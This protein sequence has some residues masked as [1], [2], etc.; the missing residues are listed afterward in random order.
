MTYRLNFG[1]KVVMAGY[2]WYIE[3]AAEKILVDAGGNSEY[4]ARTR[5]VRVRTIQS[6]DA[7]L[8][9][10]GIN[11]VD[12]DLVILTHLHHDHVAQAALFSRA[13]F[14]VQRAELEF[15]QKPHP[16]FTWAYPGEFFEGLDFEVISGDRSICDG[17]S[18]LS[19]PG[20]TPGGGQSVCVKVTH[21]IAIIPGLCTIRE[22]Y[23]P[24]STID[25]PVIPPSIHT[26]VLTA[27][28]S[29]LR[30]KRTADIIVPPHDTEF[31]V[32]TC[33]V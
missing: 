22:N 11:P 27:Y 16:L 7:G 15:A 12:I 33:I 28:D 8:G 3:G 23:K 19:T 29:V 17:V 5:G 10:L 21:G 9:K 32:K 20:H 1:R 25:M 30:I 13:K 14:L 31:L 6:L 4:F 2:A 18:V 26:D 24:P